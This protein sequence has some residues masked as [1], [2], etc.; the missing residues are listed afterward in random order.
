[1][2]PRDPITSRPDR[3]PRTRF[4][5]PWSNLLRLLTA[6]TTLILVMAL[7]FALPAAVSPGMRWG[8]AVTLGLLLL[9]GPACMVRGYELTPHTLYILRPGWN[10][11]IPLAGLLSV[12]AGPDLTGKSLRLFGNAG[13]W[14]FTGLYWNSRLGRFRLFANDGSRSVVL[15]FPHRRVVVAPDD[16]TSFVEELRRRSGLGA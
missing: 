15:R 10:T 4:A 16:P 9:G 14:S 11:P 1:M 2:N 3:R 5:A 6:L 12:E 8:I 7:W 13:F